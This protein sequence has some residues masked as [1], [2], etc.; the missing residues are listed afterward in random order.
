MLLTA[1][2]ILNRPTYCVLLLVFIVEFPS[3]VA[4]SSLCTLVLVHIRTSVELK[5][6]V[7]LYLYLPSRLS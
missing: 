3:F 5:E 7:Q 1:N 2:I 6:R 4:L